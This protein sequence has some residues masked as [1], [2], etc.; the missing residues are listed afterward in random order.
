V[1]PA[2]LPPLLPSTRPHATAGTLPLM[3]HHATQWLVVRL[4]LWLVVRLVVRHHATQGPH[5]KTSFLAGTAT[6]WVC[7]ASIASSVAPAP[8]LAACRLPPAAL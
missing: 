3:R 7:V 4:F 2:S 1:A 6:P 8:S 5:V